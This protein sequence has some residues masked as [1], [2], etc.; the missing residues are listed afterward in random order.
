MATYG[1]YS[2][3]V[4]VVSTASIGIVDASLSASIRP[5]PGAVGQAEQAT[6]VV[7]GGDIRFWSDGG[8][9]TASV[10]LLILD[11]QSFQLQS[12]EEIA[13]FKAIRAGAGDATLTIQ[14]YRYTDGTR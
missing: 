13:N 8:V 14:L 11:G 3:G 1:A 9:P 2:H 6:V 12:P 7:E 10:G 5:G 4:L